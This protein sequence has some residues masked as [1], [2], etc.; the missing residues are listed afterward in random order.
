MRLFGGN[1]LDFEDHA[2]RP[3]F[4]ISYTAADRPW[5]EWIAWQLEEHGGY[6]VRL[7]AWDFHP[8]QNFVLEMDRASAES[9]RTLVVLSPAFLSSVYTQPEWATAIRRDPTGSVGTVVPVRVRE[10][11]PPAGLLGPLIWIDLVG[12]EDAEARERLLAGLR[13]D[14]EGR[15]VRAKPASAPSLPDA[16][17]GDGRPG[18]PGERPP[19]WNVPPAPGRFV[20]REQLLER[21]AGDQAAALTQTR[22]VHGLGGVGK[23]RLAVEFARRHRDDYD[24]VWWVRAE[25]EPTRLS[26]YAALAGALALP[27]AQ[28]ADGEPPVPAVRRWL[29]AHERWLLVLDNAPGPESLEMLIPSG[30][31]G[32]VLITS[33]REGGWGRLAAPCPVDVWS[34]DESVR[35][36]LGRTGSSDAQGA[37][38]IAEALGDLPLALE[39]AGAYADSKGLSLASYERRLRSHAPELFALGEPPDYEHTVATTWELAFAEIE[40]DRPAASLLLCAAFL[41]PETIPA[42]LFES[43]A[44]ADGAFAGRDG[45]RALDEAREQLRRYSLL[46]G[47]D[48]ALTMHR[49]VQQIARER[50][51]ADDMRRWV[52]V[53][54]QL[55]AAGFPADGEDPAN[56]P[57]CARLLPHGLAVAEHAKATAAEDETTAN[58]LAGETEGVA[59]EAVCAGA[60]PGRS[61]LDVRLAGYDQ[62]RCRADRRRL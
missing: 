48:E 21:L 19:V 17:G 26:D 18:F 56:W 20:G 50:L 28:K 52:G 14:A 34:R 27:E 38:A 54:Q 51:G 5:A 59:D 62:G 43:E 47:S 15:P 44:L 12:L 8:G 53:A 10:C 1:E 4:F 13:L 36:L 24:V 60:R 49:L 45:W 61:C 32:Q 3:D 46:T 39:Q 7:Q 57:A 35:F 41:A 23:T 2:P 29:E 16:P 40:Q 11:D 30:R 31:G 55:V 37:A 9:E 58:L 25:D 6:P 33:R 22:A 42:E